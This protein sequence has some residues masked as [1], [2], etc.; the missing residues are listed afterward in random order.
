MKSFYGSAFLREPYRARLRDRGG[1]VGIPAL[2]DHVETALPQ[3]PIVLE[4]FVKGDAA[5]KLIEG[6]EEH[7]FSDVAG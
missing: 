5:S 3:E 6:V 4:D 2:V 7:G 1:L